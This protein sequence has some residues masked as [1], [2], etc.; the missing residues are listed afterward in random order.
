M[1]FLAKSQCEFVTMT[2]ISAK[3][4][5]ATTSSMAEQDPGTVAAN[6][7]ANRVVDVDFSS[8]RAVAEIVKVCVDDLEI[9][10]IAADERA[11]ADIGRS[12]IDDDN[13]SDHVQRR[14]ETA[15]EVAFCG[16]PLGS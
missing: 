12:Q 1:R 7:V 15:P 11:Q 2:A 6:S 3:R 13:L 4:V 5:M 9:L 10:L 14:A 8:C 16:G